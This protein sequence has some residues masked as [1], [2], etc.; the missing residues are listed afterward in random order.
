[1]A[2]TKLINDPALA[3][4]IAS[5]YLDVLTEFLAE[6]DQ[7]PLPLPVMEHAKLVLMDTLGIILAT[8]DTAEMTSF[9]GSILSSPRVRETTVLRRGFPQTEAAWAALINGTGATFFILD[10]SHPT[11]GHYAVHIV[12]A[13]LAMAEKLGLSGRRLIES[14]ILGYETSARLGSA[15][16][17]REAFHPHGHVGLVGAAVACAKLMG[18]GREELK[19]AINMASCLTLAAPMK[20]RLEGATVTNL[21]TG[22][23]AYIGTL[24][25]QLV[26]DG[27]KGPSDGLSETFA[28]L[29]HQDF[30][31]DRI[32]QGLGEDYEILHNTLRLYACCGETHAA[33]DAT[34]SLM[35]HRSL[36][37]DDISHIEVRTYAEA[38]AWN[39]KHPDNPQAA[40]FSVPYV[41]AAMII[42]DSCGIETFEPEMIANEDIQE[43]AGK[44][45]VIADPLLT[46]RR[47]QHSSAQ[48]S[49]TLNSGETMTA[50]RENPRGHPD[51]PLSR[52]EIEEKFEGLVVSFFGG[53]TL[54]RAMKSVKNL[55]R[56][57][58]LRD[59]TALLR[60]CG[61]QTENGDG[62]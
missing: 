48:V 13:A 51:N 7:V 14:F 6:A 5:R 1:M 17:R 61:A 55:D 53:D 37:A 34:R 36:K 47:P 31:S 42:R 58:D 18:L 40:K 41:V 50:F 12:P 23:S 20:A 16:R 32:P 4:G 46:Q 45:E 22:L 24:I 25:P 30:C 10:E 39:E 11:I 43:L 54:S 27:F 15:C 26:K 38:A 35:E 2:N 62:R 49:I 52:R 8:S 9:S 44:V 33:I 21:W 60:E 57:D 28:H 3:G 56:F 29:S 59:F 19:E